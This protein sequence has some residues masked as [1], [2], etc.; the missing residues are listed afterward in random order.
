[1]RRV[2]F[3]LSRV[4]GTAWRGRGRREPEQWR[5]QQRTEAGRMNSNLASVVHS[6]KALGY[7]HG[8][9]CDGGPPQGQF[10]VLPR[11]ARLLQ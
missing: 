5:S 3:L 7:F 4:M 6:L 10:A 8:P 9:A 1:M 2:L 11:C